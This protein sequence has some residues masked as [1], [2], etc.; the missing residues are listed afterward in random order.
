MN[1]DAFYARFSVL[2]TENLTQMNNTYLSIA[3]LLK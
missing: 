3:Y 1:S 2:E